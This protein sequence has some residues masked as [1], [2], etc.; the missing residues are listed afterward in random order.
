MRN[1]AINI[2]FIF[3]V[4][5]GFC[6]PIDTVKIYHIKVHSKIDNTLFKYVQES[7]D[8]AESI[9]ADIILLDINSHGG[10]VH[11]G[12]NIRSI[13]M[14]TKIHVISYVRFNAISGAAYVAMM[15]DDL[16]MH[17]EASIGAVT[18]VNK[19]KDIM[20]V[21]FQRV[22]RSKMKTLAISKGRSDDIAQKMVG[23][24]DSVGTVTD[25]LVLTAQEAYDI[26]FCS[27]VYENIDDIFND[28]QVISGP[29]KLYTLEREERE[30]FRVAAIEKTN[31]NVHLKIIIAILG[32]LLLFSWG[33]TWEIYK[34]YKK[35]NKDDKS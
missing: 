18:V 34:L 29:Y 35:D 13:L 5:S 1:L 10:Y 33:K 19:D 3:M 7:V 6:S 22:M 2:L 27:A 4:L 23:T 26:G 24:L 8:S 25:V 32:F 30:N 20:E 12:D 21:K 17:P 28:N 11:S 16:F 15:G 31:E 9:G 14:N